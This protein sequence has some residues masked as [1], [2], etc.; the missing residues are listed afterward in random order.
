MFPKRD[1][2][3][4]CHGCGKFHIIKTEFLSSSISFAFKTPE[5]TTWTVQGCGCKECMMENKKDGRIRDAF[6]NGMKPE[7]RERAEKEFN[8]YWLMELIKNKAQYR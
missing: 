6:R 3:V 1:Y 5:G 2:I 8:D 4:V 7:V